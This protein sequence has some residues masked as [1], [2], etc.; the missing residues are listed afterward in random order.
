MKDTTYSVLFNKSDIPYLQRYASKIRLTHD[1][2]LMDDFN[3]ASQRIWDDHRNNIS[4][5]GDITPIQVSKADDLIVNVGIAR[6]I[7]ATLVPASLLA[8]VGVGTGTT[9][10]SA[11]QTTLVTQVGSRVDATASGWLERA[12]VTLR[13]ASIFGETFTSATINECGIFT[14]SSGGT[15]FNR[16]MFSNAPITHTI[17]ITG[18]VISS[19]IEFVPIV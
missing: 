2:R 18:F 15:M 7:D 4:I 14:A 17:N 13:I 1:K 19:I 11:G 9:A 8:W 12:G 16:N 3:L 6:F 10:V 5:D